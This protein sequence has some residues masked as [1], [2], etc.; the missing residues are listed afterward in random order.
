MRTAMIALAALTAATAA[1]PAPALAQTADQKADIRCVLVL[2]AVGRDPKQ[3]QAAMQGIY[4][5]LGR[6]DAA[7]LKPG[8][9]GLMKTEGSAIQNPQQA[10]AELNRCGVELNRRA[11]DLKATYER[12]Q[13]S[14]Q[15]A[16]PPAK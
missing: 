4:Y 1:A 8:L 2:G 14:A 13:A 5:F 6:I 12:L 16:K 7:G 10:Q 15:A 11:A 9:E 3:Q